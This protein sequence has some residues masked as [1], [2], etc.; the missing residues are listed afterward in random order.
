MGCGKKD[1]GM[2]RCATCQRAWYCNSDCQKKDWGNHKN[3]C[4]EIVEKTLQVASKIKNDRARSR[5]FPGMRYTYYWGN[6]PAVDLLNLSMN[7]GQEYSEPLALL[8]CGVGDPRNILLTIASLPDDYKQQVTFVLNDICPCTLARTVLLLYIL[9]TGGSEAVDTAIR[10]WYSLCISQSDFSLLKSALEEL[11]AAGDLSTLT[12]DCLNV[13]TPDQLRELKRVW[14]TWVELSSG[15]RG[16]WVTKRRN[17][18]FQRDSQSK[19]GI[20]NYLKSIPEHHRESAKLWMENGLF[21]SKCK[22][23]CL[24]IENVTLTGSPFQRSEFES[25]YDFCIQPG[26]LPFSGWDYKAIKDVCYNDSLPEMYCS[27]LTNIMNMCITK[28]RSQVKLYVIRCD[29]MAMEQFLSME[30]KYDRITTSNLSDYIS[31]TILLT[32]NTNNSHSVLVTEVQNWEDNYFP[33]VQNQI[34]QN[35]FELTNKVVKDTNNPSLLFTNLSSFVEYHDHIPDFQLYLRAALLSSHAMTRNL[36]F[37]Q[38]K[39]NFHRSK[40]SLPL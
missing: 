14:Q 5:R 20:E 4:H 31:L 9:C 25:D 8:L 10:V 28:L 34:R 18:A 3:R 40:L 15:H 13:A 19:E 11:L 26:N 22:A 38:I 33:E 1:E 30:L 7:E 2:L 36:L 32:V 27:Y 29:C 16:R 24:T 37:W 6:P 23:S 17:A 35:Y 12:N 39:R 21:A